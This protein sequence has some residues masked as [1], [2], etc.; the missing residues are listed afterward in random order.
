MKRN[1]NKFG[2]IVVAA[3]FAL[4]GVNSYAGGGS[5]SQTRCTGVSE[6]GD[7]IQVSFSRHI[8]SLVEGASV[9]NF[10]IMIGGNLDRSINNPTVSEIG[11]ERI[12]IESSFQ[13]FIHYLDMHFVDRQFSQTEF[14]FV[15][16]MKKFSFKGSCTF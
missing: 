15:S 2:A 12:K 5:T 9:P 11:P 16:G 4:V 14:E 8:N 6:Q 7:R 10:I 3:L 1:N 13:G